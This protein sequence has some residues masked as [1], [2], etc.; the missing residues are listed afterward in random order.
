[1]SRHKIRGEIIFVK[2]RLAR[3][4]LTSGNGRASKRNLGGGGLTIAIQL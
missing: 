2:V 4:P 1:V 3:K